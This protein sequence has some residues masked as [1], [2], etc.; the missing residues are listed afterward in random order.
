MHSI[1][2]GTTSNLALVLFCHNFFLL[3]LLLSY[4]LYIVFMVASIAS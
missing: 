3:L 1:V 2:L 4:K